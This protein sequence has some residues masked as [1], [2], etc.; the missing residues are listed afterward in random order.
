MYDGNGF[1]PGGIATVAIFT[2]AGLDGLNQYILGLA[3]VGPIYTVRLY[4]N[5][6]VFQLTSV[7]AV[8]T[9]C[10][11]PGYAAIA[12]NPLLWV[13]GTV[14]GLTTYT[15]PTLTWTFTPFAGPAQT[16]FGYYVTDQTGSTD[17]GETAAVGFTVP[18]TG[19]QLL[20]TPSW[21]DQNLFA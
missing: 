6:V 14:A 2:N 7:T 12:L 4:V 20:L 21:L 18:I 11:L 1:R 17:W 15:Y 16:V 3:N 5:N 13:G 9:E 8:F 19:G 10:T